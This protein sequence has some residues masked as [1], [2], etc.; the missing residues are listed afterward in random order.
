MLP[1]RFTKFGL[2]GL[3]CVGLTVNALAEDPSQEAGA[4]EPDDDL[5]LV[6]EGRWNS[7]YANP[8]V[9]WNVYQKIHLDEATVA[10]RKN[11]MRDQNRAGDPF[12]VRSSDME[13]IKSGMA[14][15]FHE[16]FTEELTQNGG[17]VMT[18]EA[19]DDVLTIKPAIVDLDVAAPDTMRAGMNRQ[20]TRSAG[21]MTLQMEL[22]D[23][24][25]GDVLAKASDRREAPDRGYMQWTS[26]VTNQA[27][28]R[29]I[30]QKWAKSLREKLDEARANSSTPDQASE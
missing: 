23:S 22:T 30:M 4:Q 13:K 26:S 20:Y 7:L 9:D 14:E 16:V 19:G 29:R 2:A 17:Y 18:T 11:W 1:N 6:S 3:L 8:E 21:K 5:V 27:E 12:K 25:T 28:A 15:M 10:F 24:V